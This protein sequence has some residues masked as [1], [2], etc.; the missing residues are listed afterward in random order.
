MTL[1]LVPF[2]E[3]LRLNLN[4]GTLLLI[5]GRRK[6]TIFSAFQIKFRQKLVILGVFLVQSIFKSYFPAYLSQYRVVDV[7][8]TR[9]IS[10]DSCAATD[11]S[12][13]AQGQHMFEAVAMKAVMAGSH[14]AVLGRLDDLLAD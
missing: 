6:I 9:S 4:L 3:V 5:P 8:Y 1:H 13:V 10:G 14:S 11:T 12:V 2:P 7:E